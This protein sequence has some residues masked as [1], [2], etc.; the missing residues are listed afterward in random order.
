MRS[1]SVSPKSRSKTTNG[2]PLDIR[3]TSWTSQMF[4]CLMP[5]TSRASRSRR[6][7]V[8]WLGAPPIEL[9]RDQA[10]L[11][12][13]LRLEDAP[14]SARSDLPEQL[15]LPV[16]DDTLEVRAGRAGRAGRARRLVTLLNGAVEAP[17]RRLADAVAEVV[18]PLAVRAPAEAFGQDPNSVNSVIISGWR[19]MGRRYRARASAVTPLEQC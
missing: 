1:A 2:V 5:A 10:L 16:E 19:A 12:E 8:S 17:A 13:V 18:W 14:D 3:P 7:I 15:V 9:D 11:L 4:G 6:T